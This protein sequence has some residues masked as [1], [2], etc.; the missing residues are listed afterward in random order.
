MEN[1]YDL[2]QLSCNPI[3]IRPKWDPVNSPGPQWASISSLLLRGLSGP[4]N[5]QI[6]YTW[7]HWQ[8]PHCLRFNLL[9]LEKMQ[10]H[11]TSPEL[12]RNFSQA[13]TPLSLCACK[14]EYAIENLPW[15]LVNNMNIGL[16]DPSMCWIIKLGLW[17][18]VVLGVNSLDSFV[19]LFELGYQLSAVKFK[20][21]LNL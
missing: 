10:K 5:S 4:V 14:C 15:I 9:P 6:C 11:P 2:S 16:L 18:T 19:K 20:C 8:T 21:G 12:K 1:Y 17:V 7:S 3:N 13:H